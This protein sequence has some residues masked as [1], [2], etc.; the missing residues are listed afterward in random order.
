[1]SET[2]APT[3][4]ERLT[5]LELA[6]FGR[7]PDPARTLVVGEILTIPIAAANAAGSAQPLPPG[8]TFTARANASGPVTVGISA[9]AG[10]PAVVVTAVSPATDVLVMVEDSKGLTMAVERFDIVPPPAPDE[11][12]PEEKPDDPTPV[13]LTL[14][15]T[16]AERAE[17]PAP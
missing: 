12:K 17:P 1:M 7:Q 9:L 3:D 6:V 16:R 13:A 14:D 5:A 8:D 11:A 4:A 10:A 2:Q 15:L